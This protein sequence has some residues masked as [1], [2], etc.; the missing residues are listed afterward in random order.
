MMIL[1]N[2]RAPC[3]IAEYCYIHDQG[4]DQGVISL[5]STLLLDDIAYI[6]TAVGAV[7]NQNLQQLGHITIWFDG[8]S[9]PELP[10]C[11]HVLGP[12]LPNLQVGSHIIFG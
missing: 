8:A 3:D 9:I 12:M 5:E 11:I 6:V 10:G 4:R 7:A 1:F 2:N